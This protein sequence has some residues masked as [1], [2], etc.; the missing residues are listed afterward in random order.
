MITLKL[1]EGLTYRID[2]LTNYTEEPD[3][4]TVALVGFQDTL[5]DQRVNLFAAEWATDR[6]AA[7]GK[8]PVFSNELG[9]YCVNLPVV[10]VTGGKLIEL[11]EDD[12]ALALEALDTARTRAEID[13][14]DPKL[15]DEARHGQHDA[16]RAI[17]DLGRKIRIAT[18]EYHDWDAKFGEFI[19]RDNGNVFQFDPDAGDVWSPEEE[20][21]TWS[22]VPE[23]DDL[24]AIPGYAKHEHVL[25][26]VMCR[27]DW[28]DEDR[29]KK[30][31]YS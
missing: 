24:I 13:S 17:I 22:I 5:K 28:T 11:T 8:Y 7:L 16:M 23:G 31:L 21:S 3:R 25:Y 29:A 18:G 2:P 10:E 6:Q 15:S 20:S 14:T 26:Y 4:G 9:M 12:I 19:H 1:A 27:K 30:W